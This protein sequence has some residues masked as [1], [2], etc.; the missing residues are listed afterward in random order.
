VKNLDKVGKASF[1]ARATAPGKG[2]ASLAGNIGTAQK[3]GYESGVHAREEEQKKYAGT[4]KNT[5]AEKDRIEAIEKED[6][7][8]AEQDLKAANAGL[9]EAENRLKSINTALN[10]NIADNQKKVAD[11]E[12]E[13]AQ[14]ITERDAARASGD[15]VL[16]AKLSSDIT[17]AQ[18]YADSLN[19]KIDVDKAQAT[20]NTQDATIL[21][22]VAK[23]MKDLAEKK[24]V[25]LKA[26]IKTTRNAPKSDFADALHTPGVLGKTVGRLTGVA[27]T[28]DHHASDAIKFELSKN[29][30]QKLI[31]ALNGAK[32]AMSSSTSGGGHGD[33]HAGKGGDDHGKDH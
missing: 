23:G 33:S 14:K 11:T 20:K 31:D 1:D 3:G 21:V 8:K 29:E 12:V 17:S 22:N 32:T 10:S 27:N 18:T 28:G 9:G 25:G 26:E 5:Q 13:I 16:A 2:L 15:A 4:L 30:S 24:V 7:P 19:K 6:L